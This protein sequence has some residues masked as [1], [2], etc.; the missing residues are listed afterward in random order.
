MLHT[1]LE[2]MRGNYI[3][4][5]KRESLGSSRIQLSKTGRAF[6]LAMLGKGTTQ[7]HVLSTYHVIGTL[8][9]L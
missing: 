6:L 3:Q 1:L 5:Y 9:T 8:Y 2:A 4:E 7:Y